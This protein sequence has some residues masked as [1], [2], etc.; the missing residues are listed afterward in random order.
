MPQHLFLSERFHAFLHRFD[1]ISGLGLPPIFD[2]YGISAKGHS[3]L[4]RLR[5]DI[6]YVDRMALL[7]GFIEKGIVKF[8]W[9]TVSQFIKDHSNDS[10]KCS[11]WLNEGCYLFKST[12]KFSEEVNSYLY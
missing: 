3:F 8:K 10:G 5:N 4:S 9:F 1:T 6:L 2:V 12:N 11:E 7:C